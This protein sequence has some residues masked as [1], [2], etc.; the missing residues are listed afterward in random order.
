MNR[1]QIN[2]KFLLALMVSV[3]VLAAAVHF[4]HAYQVKRQAGALLER[5][6]RAAEEEKFGQAIEYLRRY[7]G[8]EPGD[9]N[10]LARYGELLDTEG[11]RVRSFRLRQRGF[12]ALEQAL[13]RLPA[14]TQD[15][16][17]RGV[18]R[19]QVDLA[20]DVGDLTAAVTHAKDLLRDNLTWTDDNRPLN[21]NER[22]ELEQRIG[23]AEELR[24]QYAEA[25]KWYKQA[26]DHAPGQIANYIRLASIWRLHLDAPEKAD[27][28]M[29]GMIDKITRSDAVEKKDEVLFQAHLA[30]A[31][32]GIRFFP[33]EIGERQA[34]LKEQA[35]K[36]VEAVK[37]RARPETPEDVEKYLV[38]AEFALAREDVVVAREVLRKGVAAHPKNL[39]LS[40]ALVRLEAADGKYQEA[41]K[42]ILALLEADPDPDPERDR[43]RRNYLLFQL[44]ELHLQEGA[45]GKAEPLLEKLEEQKPP[46]S[47]PRVSYLRARMHMLREE[48]G[49][50]GPIL[51]KNRQEWREVLRLEAQVNLLLGQCYEQLGNPDQALTTYQ[52]ALKLEPASVAARRAVAGTLLAL[53]RSDEALAEY[54]QLL[55]FAKRP[56]DSRLLV[57]RLLIARTLRSPAEPKRDWTEVK[58]ELALATQ[59]LSAPATEKVGAALVERLRAE[60]ILLQADVTLLEDPKQIDKVHA[61]MRQEVTAHPG[62]VEFWLALAN[63]D[64]R[65][66]KPAEA[67]KTLTEAE[68]QLPAEADAKLAAA[69]W[70]D[71]RLAR[72]SYLARLPEAEARPAL[73][74]E[75]KEAAGW[76]EEVR[77]RLLEGLAGAYNRVGATADAQRLWQQ[78]ARERPNDLPLRLLLLDQALKDGKDERATELLADLRVIEGELGTFW[79]FGEAARLVVRALAESKD[80]LTDAGQGWLQ[81]ARG[82]LDDVAKRR[83]SWYRVPALQGEIADLEGHADTATERYQQAVTLGDRRP[84]VIRRLVQHQFA[85][86]RYA[87][88]GK[89]MRDLREQEQ[90]L[91]LAGLGKL[92]S[93]SKLGSGDQGG[94]L[95]LALKSVDPDSKDFRDHIFLGQ[96]YAAANKKDEAEKAFRKACD[97]GK[98]VPDPWVT[99]VVF[100]AVTERKADAEA[101]IEQARKAIAADRAPLALANCYAVV[102]QKE[103]AEKE[104]QAALAAQPNNWRVLRNLAAYYVALGDAPKAESHLR[105]LLEILEQNVRN[106][107]GS[108]RASPEDLAGTRRALASVLASAPNQRQFEEALALLEQNLRANGNRVEDR[109]LKAALLAT[110]ISQRKAAITLIEE[111]KKEQPLSAD[112]QYLLFRLY[113]ADGNWP[114]AQATMLVLL[115]SPAGEKNAVFRARYARRLLR[116]GQIDEAE[117]Q[118][119][120][121]KDLKDPLDPK[122]G[123]P[124]LAREI[125]ARVL[126]AR[127]NDDVKA[128]AALEAYA[129]GKD[130]DIGVAAVLADEF[131]QDGNSREL[132]RNV[133]EQLYKKYVK[134]SKSE[135]RYL[136]LASFFARQ[137]RIDETFDACQEALRDKAAPEAVANTLVAALRSGEPKTGQFQ[138]VDRWFQETV[139]GAK[140]PDGL[141]VSLADLRDLQER[142]QEAETLY[143]QVLRRKEGHLLALNNLAWLLAL[144]EGRAG[145]ALELVSRGIALVGP[146]PELLDTRGVVY[147]KLRKNDEAIKDFQACID[148]TPS[149]PRYF[150]L[151]LAEHQANQREAALEAWQKAKGLDVKQLHPL[152]HADYRKLA[153]ALQAQ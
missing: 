16:K 124:A 66:K 26:A 144:K 135:G 42:L 113:E 65:D 137:G 111:V 122:G 2:L 78:V 27:E 95:E 112:E 147:L 43:E 98:D 80:K 35:R 120:A 39:P 37:S 9:N 33:G 136:A 13:Q 110:R 106:G 67:L 53:G 23:L 150:H 19:R 14:D 128:M 20:I 92:A 96:L 70:A 64:G 36:D 100:L 8:F 93:L 71:L 117:Q 152:E 55:S 48:W 91:M 1:R 76:A 49:K 82:F 10:A 146:S 6:K 46:Y 139:A 50:A 32:Y 138:R 25:V 75:E 84:L 41:V 133:A 5:S 89:L 68:K 101:V 56:L 72:F 61:Q 31:R 99:L 97:L 69:R 60:A 18:R 123:P 52:Q 90:T 142:Y 12:T 22:S 54:R 77:P 28:L 129:A 17:W 21:D 108:D 45:P 74:A 40:E 116:R 149:A 24:K 118:L 4:G 104:F 102:G 3:G 58:A 7:L 114:Q 62:Q 44:A 57:A 130:T 63:L 51:E 88:V 151:A 134:E 79:R 59:E 107:P 34:N 119:R 15:P 140:D 47:P 148:Q 86:K 131:S 85:Q 109:R 11:K 143:A 38:E 30:R 87:E 141:L 132:Y 121:L 145:E 115:G 105:K 81:E 153:A 126:R 127:G 125:E 103:K 73:A 29:E 83:P 94:A